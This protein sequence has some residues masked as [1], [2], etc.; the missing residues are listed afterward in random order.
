METPSA[1]ERPDSELWLEAVSGT[2][3]SFASLYRR[4]HQRVF[5]KAYFRVQDVS[6]AEDIT[7]M[8]FLEAWRS[9]A[10]VRIVDGSLLPWLLVVTSNVSLNHE[11]SRRRYRRLLARLP[12]VGDEV[13]PAEYAAERLDSYRRSNALTVALGRL[14][15]RERTI[16]D[17]CLVEELPLA[18]VARALNIPVG[19][20]KS[21]L[22]TARRKLRTHLADPDIHLP[23]LDLRD[24]AREGPSRLDTE[25]SSP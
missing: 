14:K 21:R 9:R 7:A 17:L 23:D 25:R 8:V 22:H 10:R 6:D 24:P 3:A 19:T 11:R 1:H 20:V 16:V 18:T 13:D 5:R 4:Y 2:A 12:P 15:S